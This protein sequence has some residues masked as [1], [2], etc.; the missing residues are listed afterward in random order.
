MVWP[1]EKKLLFW[2]T[3]RYKCI[4][5]VP[6]YISAYE[7]A[8]IQS[9]MCMFYMYGSMVSLALIMCYCIYDTKRIIS[10]RENLLAKDHIKKMFETELKVQK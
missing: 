3:N 5:D 8:R 1:L 9:K 2:T 4:E 6:N 10:N 7:K